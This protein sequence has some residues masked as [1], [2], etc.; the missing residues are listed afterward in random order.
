MT[1]LFAFLDVETTGLDPERDSI[2][3]IAWAFTHE[4]FQIVG[5]PTSLLVEPRRG[6]DTFFHA[7]RTNDAVRDMHSASGLFDDLMSADV[8]HTDDVV[9]T[10][11]RQVEALPAHSSLHLAG[12]SVHFDRAF[13]QAGGFEHVLQRFHHRHLDL[14]SVKLLLGTLGV[15][16]DEPTNE[17]PHRALSDVL[18]S[19]EQARLFAHQFAPSAGA[20]IA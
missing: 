20:L 15:P 5:T 2:V 12:F 9:M 7:L 18:A 16:F 13:L 17:R 11:L 10:L 6:W 19:V 4:S 1:R 8:V 3:E 14:S